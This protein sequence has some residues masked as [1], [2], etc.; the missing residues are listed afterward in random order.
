[1]GIRAVRGHIELHGVRHR[2]GRDAEIHPFD[3][4]S[5]VGGGIK[6]IFSGEREDAECEREQS[7]EHA[8][9]DTG[10]FSAPFIHRNHGFP[11]NFS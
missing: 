10:A 2:G 11:P 3:I 9:Q 5:A 4:R 7:S 6:R 1:M 8:G